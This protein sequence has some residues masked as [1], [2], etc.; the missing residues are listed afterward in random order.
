MTRIPIRLSEECYSALQILA[1]QEFRNVR[2]QA[3]WIIEQELER[4]GL[5]DNES[6]NS[7]FSSVGNPLEEGI[8]QG[9]TLVQGVNDVDE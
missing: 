6:N 2:Q 9:E 5:L 1:L 3:A 7:M 8:P 4:R